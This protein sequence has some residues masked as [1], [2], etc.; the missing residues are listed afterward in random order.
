ML[1]GGRRQPSNPAS[2]A[3]KILAARRVPSLFYSPALQEKPMFNEI[4]H[5]RRFLLG[6][7]AMSFVASQFAFAGAADAQPSR[8]KH[9][10]LGATKPGTYTSFAP[11]KQI[12]AGVLN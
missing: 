8:P 11:L 9:A 4:D 1:S 10:N 6:A 5:D 12:D 2:K 3:R 7:A